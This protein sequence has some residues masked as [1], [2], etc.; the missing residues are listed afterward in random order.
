MNRS[1]L[2]QLTE[3]RV[4]ESQALLAAGEAAGAYYVAGY[5]VECALKACIAKQTQQYDFPEKRLV[6]ASHTHNLSEL[7]GLAGL[8]PALDG[9]D[10]GVR[11]NW[12]IA[13]DWS[14]QSRYELR[15][16]T[17]AQDLFDA[18]SDPSDGVLTWL[19]RHW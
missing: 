13:K 11:A 7:L 15:T 1:D 12:A 8:R 2:H 16:L 9:A 4:R 19:R 14:E 5:A 3:A 17:E 10:A 18:L 6:N